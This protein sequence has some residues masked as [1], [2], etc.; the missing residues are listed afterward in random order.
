[1]FYLT[2]FIRKLVITFVE[3][4]SVTN[5]FTVLVWCCNI[6]VN[7]NLFPLFVVQSNHV[8]GIITGQ[9]FNEFLFKN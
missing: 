7:S 3:R 6:R 2:L 5:T 8:D 4:M 1:M 9:G